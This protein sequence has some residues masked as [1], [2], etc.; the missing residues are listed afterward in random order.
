MTPEA[1]RAPRV[2]QIDLALSTTAFRLNN[3]GGRGT[4]L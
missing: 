1:N 3:R 2:E 4:L